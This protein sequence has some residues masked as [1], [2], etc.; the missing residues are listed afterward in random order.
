MKKQIYKKILENLILIR[1]TE[2]LI[3][4]E[5]AKIIFDVQFIYQLDKKELVLQLI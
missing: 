3:S 1:K 2:E 5:Y 4:R